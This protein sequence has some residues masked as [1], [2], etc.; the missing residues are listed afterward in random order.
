[1]K[2]VR[3]EHATDS[4]LNWLVAK[5]RGLNV[6]FIQD[7]QKFTYFV[8]DEMGMPHEFPNYAGDWNQGGTL[9]PEGKV[10]VMWDWGEWYAY[11]VGHTNVHWAETYLKAGIRVYVSIHLG[12]EAEVPDELS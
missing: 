3:I 2:K 9:L 8:K 1:M 10:T 12:D 5:I 4:Q 6:Y 11:S 7:G